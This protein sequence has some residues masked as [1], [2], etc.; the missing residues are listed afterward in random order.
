M[1]KKDREAM[2]ELENQEQENMFYE[3]INSTYGKL[4][5]EVFDAPLA[6]RDQLMLDLY[7]KSKEDSN[8]NSTTVERNISLK[9]DTL[10]ERKKKIIAG[11]YLAHI[12]AVC[13]ENFC[14]PLMF[15]YDKKKPNLK[16]YYNES[17]LVRC[18]D[19][20]YTVVKRSGFYCRP[21]LMP[22]LTKSLLASYGYSTKVPFVEDKDALLMILLS[23]FARLISPT[24]Y[25]N[26]WFVVEVINNVSLN[27]Y[28]TPDFLYSN[29][30]L[31]KQRMNLAKFIISIYNT[32][33]KDNPLVPD[34]NKPNPL[35]D[36]T[37]KEI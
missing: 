19:D 9:D 37:P 23:R 25:K 5:Q 32:Y 28:A 11:C 27:A 22:E 2:I 6:D 1:S 12:N 16:K 15:F 30:K 4:F 24:D 34:V 26:I 13:D 7:T 14:G 21:E 31:H 35:E 29:P 36:N 8:N 33:F 10:D 17:R 20:L 3:A 18:V